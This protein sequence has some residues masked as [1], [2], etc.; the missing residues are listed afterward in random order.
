MS[1]CG[2]LGENDLYS[3]Y[4]PSENEIAGILQFL[5]RNLSARR[6]IDGPQIILTWDPP[7]DPESK[8]TLIRIVRKLYS[9]S[10]SEIDGKIVFEGSP[11]EVS[12]ADYEDVPANKCL[13]YTIWSFDSSSGEWYSNVSTQ[14]SIVAFYTGDDHWKK[15]FEFMGEAI[16]VFDKD[17]PSGGLTKIPL[18]LTFADDGEAFNLHE[19]G[20]RKGQLAR[21]YKI[22]GALVDEAKELISDIPNQRNVNEACSEYLPLI[23]SI[24]GFDV[25]REIPISRQRLEISNRVAILKI[26]GTIPSIEAILQSVTGFDVEVKEW[27]ENQFISNKIKSLT[28]KSNSLDFTNIGTIN[29]TVH[30]SVG[31]HNKS[32]S[33]NAISIFIN[34][35]SSKKCLP[36]SVIKKSARALKEVLPICVHHEMIWKDEI[37][38]EEYEYE[39]EDS[40]FTNAED[41]Y[42]ENNIWENCYIISNKSDKMSNKIHHI[43]PS[44]GGTCGESYWDIVTTGELHSR[45]S[46]PEDELVP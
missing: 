5:V 33:C 15:L 31:R 14:V 20:E 12:F 2:P 36:L 4:S 35:L 40:Y 43:T 18:D 8:V 25:N 1:S 38:V 24:I 22:I 30:Y 32:R 29:D 10:N 45:Y 34:L 19:I 6:G 27:C 44:R 46:V 42:V 21:F 41:S 28:P 39:I 37:Y 16:I 3:R 13:Y 7:E 23:A 17:I 11:S 9:Y 26:K